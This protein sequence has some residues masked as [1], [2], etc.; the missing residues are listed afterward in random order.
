V[1][2]DLRGHGN[3]GLPW[4]PDAYD[5]GR[6][7]ADDVNAVIKATGLEKPLIVGWSY[8]GNVVMDFARYHPET[9]VS[10]YFLVSTTGG[11]IKFPAPPANAPVRPTASPNLQLNI[12]AVDASTNFLFPASVDA[13]LR[14]Q[15]KAAA[16]RVSP[17][18]D[19]AIARRT[20]YDNLDLVSRLDVPV[21]FVFGGKD[22]IVS[23]AVA[24]TLS[25]LVPK[26]KAVVFPNA[27]HGLFIEDP[28]TFNKLLEAHT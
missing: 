27:G 21:T 19:Q 16:M 13:G 10:G 5:E 18:V 6:P 4:Q 12:A 23:P 22:P 20:G 8:G 3:S 28:E 15:F 1:A 14:D 24:Q 25:S 11:F 17:F 7:W 9:P 26:A 2:F